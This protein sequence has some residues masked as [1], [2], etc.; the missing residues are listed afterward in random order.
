MLAAIQLALGPVLQLSQ[1][2]LSADI[3][4]GAA[5]G[6]A[7]LNYRLDIPH[8]GRDPAHDRMHD[9]AFFNRKVYNVFPPLV[10]LLTVILAPLHRLLA[11]PDGTWVPFI[12]ELFVFWPLPIVGFLVFRRQCGDSAWAAFLTVAWMGGTALLPNLEYTRHGYLGPMNHVLSQTGLL[13]LAAD[14][15]GRQ[16]IWPAL[17]GLFIAVW[18]RQMTILYALPLCWVAWRRSRLLVCLAGLTLIVMPILALNWLKFGSVSEFGYQYIYVNRD[19]VLAQRA[20]RGLFSPVFFFENLWFMHAEL[21]NFEPGLTHMRVA[22]SG[23]GASIWFTSPMLLYVLV[24]ARR[25][26]RDARRRLLML[27][28]LPVMLGLLFYHTTGFMQIGYNRFALDFI[29]IW[30]VIVAPFTRGGWRTWFSLGA[31]AWSLL[32]FQAVIRIG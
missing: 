5:E 9:T 25:W 31:A 24:D 26:W 30:L 10:P 4:A 8:P 23:D 11:M 29:P 14:L 3:D 12:E 18:T 21:P 19:D 2:G 6:V 22:A 32:Y 28:T 27:S 15:L 1:W 17:I 16:R 20:R 13:I 7:W